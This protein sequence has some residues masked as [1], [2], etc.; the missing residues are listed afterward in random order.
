MLKELFS[1]KYS[2]PLI[3]EMLKAKKTAMIA[4]NFLGSGLIIVALYGYVPYSHLILWFLLNMLI[5]IFRIFTSSNLYLSIQNDTNDVDKYLKQYLTVTTLNGLLFGIIS[6]VSIFYTIPDMNFVIIGVVVIALTAGSI[7]TLGTI[8]IGFVA[9]VMFST[10]PL[11]FALVYH[12]GML[13]YEFAIILAIYSIIHIKSGH[14]LFLTYQRNI[15]LENKFKKTYDKSSDGSAIIKNKQILEC[16]DALSNMFGYEEKDNFFATSLFELSPLKQSNNKS[17]AKQMLTMLKKSQKNLVVFEWV[18]MKKCGTKFWVEIT[19]NSIN[20]NNE[21]VIHGVWRNIDSRKKAE[22]EVKNLNETLVLR[23]NDEVAKNREKDKQ[24][25]QQ[26]RLA[27]MGEMI[28]MIAHQW[29]QPLTAISSTSTGLELKAKL[30]KLDTETIIKQTQNISKYSQ[31]LS[32]TINDFRDFYKPNKEVASVTLEK[33]F[34]KSFNLIKAS[35]SNEGIEMIYDFGTNEEVQVHDNEIIQVILN[36]L[37]NAQDNFKEK[38]TKNP[39]IMITT[40]DKSMS[41]CDNGGGVSPDILEKIFDPYFST[42]DEKNGT[43]L[44]LYMSKIIVEE[45]HDAKLHVENKDDGVCL[46]IEFKKA[47]DL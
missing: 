26:S 38:E 11:M 24:L 13:F 32:S 44:G 47:N 12:G 10:I 36:I 6:L 5:S 28:S 31:H 22:Q 34:K 19:L 39:K 23:V 18:H 17:S 4:S 15:E 27:Q 1:I 21:D 9:Y 14:R 16:N 8:F 45:H 3:L 41:I 7:T 35:L 33:V 20:I 40:T 25:M 30:G 46:T 43:G 42:K 37:K 2:N 29:R